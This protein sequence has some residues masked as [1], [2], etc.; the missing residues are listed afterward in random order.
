[1]SNSINSSTKI[2]DIKLIDNNHVY[3]IRGGVLSIIVLSIIAKNV[4]IFNTSLKTYLQSTN[5]ELAKNH[6]YYRDDFR[7][8][9]PCDFCQY[10]PRL[11]H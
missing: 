3:D 11:F 6:V 9:D 10:A 5:I 2:T 8:V 7:F 1:M 4:F